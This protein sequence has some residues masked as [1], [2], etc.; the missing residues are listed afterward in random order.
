MC[1]TALYPEWP[2]AKTKGTSDQ[3]AGKVVAALKQLKSTDKAA[4]DAKIM[5]WTDSL[6]YQGVEDLQKKL[7]VGAYK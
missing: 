5:G 1:S 7:K 4:Q 3:I 6:D 2:I